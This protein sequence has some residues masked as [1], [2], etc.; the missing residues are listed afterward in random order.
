VV[1]ENA[2]R[3]CDATDAQIYRVEREML[4]HAASYGSLPVAARLV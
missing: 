2:A 1:A 3:L 4:R